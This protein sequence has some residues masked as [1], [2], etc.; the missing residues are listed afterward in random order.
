MPLK[1]VFD[2]APLTSA[3]RQPLSVGLVR[4]DSA[5]LTALYNAVKDASALTALEGAFRLA[6]IV[7]AKPGE[8]AAAERIRA[9]L[10]LQR[11]DGSFALSHRESIALL[12][13]AWA[14]YEYEARKPQLEHIAKWC[15]WA[16]QHWDELM[17]DD[18][19][20]A[21]A[22]ELMELLQN[23]YRVTG[24]AALLSLCERVA[25]QSLNWSSVLNTV[26]SQRPTNKTVTYE[27]LMNGLQKED[28]SREGYYTHFLRTNHPESLADGARSTLAKGHY[29]GSATELNASRT[30]WEKLVRH[31][32]A[33]CGGLTSDE[34]LEG[35]SPASAVS[36]AALGAWAEALAAA[37]MEANGAWAWDALERMAYNGMPACIGKDGVAAFQRVNTL[38]DAVDESALFHVMDDHDDR[39]AARLARGYAALYSA[40][41]SA[42]PDG[43]AINLYLPGRYAVMVGDQLLVLTITTTEN[44]ANIAVSC[45]QPIKA[46]LHLR[47]PAWCR[48][49]E[50][51]VNNAALGEEMENGMHVDRVWNDGDV[52]TVNM[53][54]TLR[55]EQGHH[56]GKCIL[57]GAVV[58]AL[59]AEQNAWNKAFE[60]VRAEDGRVAAT[61]D[62]VT[63]WKKHDGEPADIPVLP[64]TAGTPAL[65]VL[66]PY[67][68]TTKRI[69][70]FPG[71]KQV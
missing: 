6:C 31:Y 60:S 14:L 39:A 65:H 55:V 62:T 34:L 7:T 32:G 66:S 27:E 38:T 43:A 28:G 67:A 16:A 42:L 21:N 37:S 49:T 45:K 68:K 13:A 48:N 56:Q 53:E 70:L 20:W 5:T 23:L 64:A 4:S 41:V 40:A 19:V 30:G 17:A 50:I 18:A 2:K 8:E 11:E 10:K 57:K 15:A 69:A 44:G 36:T 54:Q 9:E 22:A 47:I 12:R 51:S 71:R 35:T 61:L 3:A 26:S 25:T 58:M 63:D 52:L 59:N 46:A 24:K 33:V 1:P 29:T